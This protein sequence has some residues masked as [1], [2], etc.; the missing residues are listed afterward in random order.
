MT[1]ALSQQSYEF[2][3]NDVVVL[4]MSIVASFDKRVEHFEPVDASQHLSLFVL[5]G[6]DISIK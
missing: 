2:Q 4:S 3:E 5:P 6:C 1:L